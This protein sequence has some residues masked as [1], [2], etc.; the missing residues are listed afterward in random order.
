MM[1]N[2]GVPHLG[3]LKKLISRLTK[4]GLPWSFSPPI[5]PFNFKR[6][7]IPQIETVPPEKNGWEPFWHGYWQMEKV[8]SEGKK[9]RDHL[10]YNEILG[11]RG[12]KESEVEKHCFLSLVN[13]IQDNQVKM[14]ELGAGR[15]DWCLSL[16]GTV[17][18]D[19]VP[20]VKDKTYRCLAVE[21]EPTHYVWT[22]EHFKKQ[23]INGGVVQGAVG[24]EDDCFVG[25]DNTTDP[26]AHYGQ[27]VKKESSYK[28]QSYTVDRLI[29][30][31]NFPKVNLIHADLQGNEL[32]AIVGAKKAMQGG[33]ID[34]WM[35]G[36]HERKLEKK[37]VKATEN[38]YNVI[39]YISRR[40]GLVNHPLYGK[41]YFPKDGLLI[42]QHKRVRS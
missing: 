7:R 30:K 13:A 1:N 2:G 28:V 38:F 5:T 33:L 3:F 36:T 41:V 32:M 17:D 34:Y 11:W 20:G 16:A 15:G 19:L 24:D 14:F 37:I 21:A 8:R 23:N 22:A 26:A 35:I 9:K 39:F 29:E 27:S 31:Y 12:L 4:E 25:F 18:F 42:L 10:S 40:S 6:W